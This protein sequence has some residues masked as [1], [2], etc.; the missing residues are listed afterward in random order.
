LRGHELTNPVDDELEDLFGVVDATDPSNG[1]IE[2]LEDRRQS[3]AL[4]S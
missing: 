1:G 4:A 2:R 3:R